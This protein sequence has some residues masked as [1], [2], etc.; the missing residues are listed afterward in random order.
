MTYETLLIGILVA[1]A[2]TEIMEIYPGGIIVPGYM[3]LYLDHPLRV[4]TTIAIAFLS[5]ATY[6]LLSRHLILYGKRRFVTLVLIG[7]LWAALWQ[8]AAPNVISDPVDLRAVG[9]LIPGLLANNL[10]KQRTVPTL[11]SLA[12]VAV[13]T[14]FVVRIIMW[15]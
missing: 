1:V 11:A 8:I 9:W 5:L 7:A 15:F 14:Y 6:R 3:A 13:M 12:T 2:Y 4:L 10:E